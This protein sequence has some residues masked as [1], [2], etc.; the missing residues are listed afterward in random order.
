M[1][2]S[3]TMKTVIKTSLR[4]AWI[5]LLLIVVSWSYFWL[6]QYTKKQRMHRQTLQLKEDIQLLNAQIDYNRERIAL[7]KRDPV[8][9]ES[10]IRRNLRWVRPGEIPVGMTN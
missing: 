9:I 10:E 7:L 8:T 6:P 2:I 5:L 4:R 1:P 3:K